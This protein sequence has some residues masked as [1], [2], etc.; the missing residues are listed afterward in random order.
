MY[1]QQI[2]EY[3]SKHK[4]E[5]LEDIGK[6]IAVQSDRSEAKPGMPFGKGPAKALELALNIA[7][8]KGLITKNYENYVG[9]VDVND[10]E[11]ELGILAH[12]DVVPAGTGWTTNPYEMVEKSGKIYGR[13][14]ADD[15]GPA[16]A[17]L[18][19][20]KAVKDLNIPLSKNVRLI[21]GTDEECGSNDI[22]YYFSKEKV[23]PKTFS[24]DGEYPVINIEKGSFR[25]SFTGRYQK[26][27]SLP[28]IISINGGLKQ[29]MVPKLCEAVI[30]G[31]TLLEVEDYIKPVAKQLKVKYEL[32]ESNQEVHITIEGNSAH[33]ST[34]ELGN[35]PITAMLTILSGMSFAKSEGFNRICSVNKLY[36][37]GD[38]YGEALGINMSDDE[39]GKLTIGLNIFE[40]NEESLKG[41][42]DCRSPLCANDDNVV[43]VMEMNMIREGLFLEIEKMNPPH[44]VDKNSELVQNLLKVYE[45]YTGKEG[46]CLAIGGGT[47]VHHIEG[48]VCFGCSMPGTD[49]HMHSSD[50]FAVIDELMLSAKMFTQIIIDIC[51]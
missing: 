14:T 18:Y 34:P 19:A 33:G 9:T 15:K 3:F 20:L 40:Y 38:F 21:L 31:F 11:T 42:F 29:N 2:E 16:V 51:A 50:E 6:L 1:K 4:K 27:E 45:D 36:P 8:E 23:P 30:E 41:S 25:S 12:L 10:K 39:S 49:N 5:L 32:L 26:N 47:Y 24:P 13:G 48:G 22:A 37:H 43:S 17:A 44:Y 46:Q 28:R 35:N 7:K